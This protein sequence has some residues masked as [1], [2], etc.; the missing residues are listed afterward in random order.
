M[1][2]KENWYLSWNQTIY[3]IAVCDWNK[4]VLI[5]NWSL[6]A[7]QLPKVIPVCDRIKGG[8][9]SGPVLMAKH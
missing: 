1:V 9:Y 8:L 5:T 4:L 3:I 7:N 6:L 2:S